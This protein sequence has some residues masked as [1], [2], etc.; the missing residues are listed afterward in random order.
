MLHHLGQHVTF[1]VAQVRVAP[2][3]RIF[4]SFLEHIKLGCAI[5]GT[6]IIRRTQFLPSIAVP[7]VLHTAATAPTEPQK[8]HLHAIFL[9]PPHILVQNPPVEKVLLWFHLPPENRNGHRIEAIRCRLF[10]H[11]FKLTVVPPFITVKLVQTDL[12]IGHVERTPIHTEHIFL[13]SIP[14]AIVHLTYRLC[15]R[16][17]GVLGIIIPCLCHAEFLHH[18]RHVFPYRRI[19]GSLCPG[20]GI[21][22]ILPARIVGFVQH[23]LGFLYR[24]F[25]IGMSHQ[26]LLVCRYP[27]QHG[28]Y[29][30]PPVFL[31]FI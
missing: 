20:Y 4:K 17:T 10:H 5:D 19:V 1:T 24:G 22:K 3:Q 2:I 16:R 12:H 14:Q 18:D 28:S 15:H 29:F 8:L 13:H 27:I 9:A 11:G 30:L 23:G 26:F 6:Y 25:Q 7:K 31:A 21:R